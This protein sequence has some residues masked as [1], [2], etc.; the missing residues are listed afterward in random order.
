MLNLY[1]QTEIVSDSD[2][3]AIRDGRMFRSYVKFTIPA[4]GSQQVL[5]KTSENVLT[6]HHGRYVTVRG[7]SVDLTVTANPTFTNE[8]TE[9]LTKFNLNSTKL[10]TTTAMLWLTPTITSTGVEIDY[11]EFDGGTQAHMVSGGNDVL[12]FERIIPQNVY[13]L[14]TFVN[15]DITNPVDVIYKLTWEELPLD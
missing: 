8:G 12:D 11:V 7:A 9:V 3:L 1:S 2:Q 13:F 6:I 4:G 14:A 10:N 15:K 5:I